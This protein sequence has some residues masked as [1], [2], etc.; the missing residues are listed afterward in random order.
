MDVLA[1]ARQISFFRF[2]NIFPWYHFR[3]CF[4]GLLVHEIRN[5]WLEFARFVFLCIVI[6]C[7]N[8]VYSAHRNLPVDGGQGC[9]EF[10]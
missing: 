3:R 6:V 10:R 8:H 9:S 7:L 4:V 5:L 2:A 1:T